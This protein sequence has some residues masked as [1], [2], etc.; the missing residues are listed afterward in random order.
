MKKGITRKRLARRNTSDAQRRPRLQRHRALSSLLVL[1][2]T[3]PLV[4]TAQAVEI[5][6]AR[7]IG[8]EFLPESVPATPAPKRNQPAPELPGLGAA[9]EST[10]PVGKEMS[11]LSKVLIGVLVV[12]TIAALGN[13]GGGGGDNTGGSDSGSGTGSSGSTPAAT[14]SSPPPSTGSG[15]GGGGGGITIGIGGGRR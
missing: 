3:L 9:P 15:G 11:T 12:G 5:Y 2:L 4:Q 7:A 8:H 14:P 13:R 6:Y 1:G 10:K